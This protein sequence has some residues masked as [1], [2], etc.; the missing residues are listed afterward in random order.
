MIE[1]KLKTQKNPYGF[2]QNPLDQNC[3]P[4]KSHAESVSHKNVQRNYAAGTCGNYHES[5]D[6]CQIVLNIQKKPY[7]VESS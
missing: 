3:T 5:S 7:F 6:M 2:K 1:S 4:K